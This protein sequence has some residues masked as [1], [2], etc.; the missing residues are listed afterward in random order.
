LQD[1]P[2]RGPS[3]ALVTVIEFSS[4]ECPACRAVDDSL[5]QLALADPSLVRIAWKDLPVSDRGRIAAR[6]LRSAARLGRFWDFYDALQK[7]PSTSMDEPSMMKIARNLGLEG[8]RFQPLLVDGALDIAIDSDEAQAHHFGLK[9]APAVFVNGK[10]VKNPT[11]ERL[12]E[13]I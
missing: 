10:F 12:Q 13:Q 11:R 9:T 8:D 1:A 2:L 5:H 3:D 6:A 4:F 7:A